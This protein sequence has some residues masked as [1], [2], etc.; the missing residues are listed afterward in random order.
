M[1]ITLILKLLCVLQH[2]PKVWEDYT[3]EY[4]NYLVCV[5]TKK[6]G[7]MS[8]SRPAFFNALLQLPIVKVK[9]HSKTA[10]IKSEHIRPR[11][12]HDP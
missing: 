6:N 4:L 8:G 2:L 1:A 10:S 7:V 11:C 3:D 5:K 9:R 12:E